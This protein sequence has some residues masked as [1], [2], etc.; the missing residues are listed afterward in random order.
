MARCACRCSRPRARDAGHNIRL[1]DAHVRI[2]GIHDRRGEVAWVARL[3]PQLEAALQSLSFQ[4]TKVR[5]D[6]GYR[7]PYAYEVTRYNEDAPDRQRI[8][9]YETDLLVY[10]DLPEGKLWVPRVVVECK[11]KG[12]TTHDALT[13]SSKAAT[14]KH[15]H[16]YLRYGPLIDSYGSA[17]LPARLVRHGAYFD[18]MAVWEKADPAGP[19][20]RT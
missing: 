2:T 7:L 13:Y 18:F 1:I 17:V 12:V 8:A 20:W 5:V 11:I 4:G 3:R 14:H 19:K 15:V 9:R 10:D 16:P 6:T